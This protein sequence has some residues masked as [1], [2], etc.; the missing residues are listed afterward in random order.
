MLQYRR[1]QSV[2][3]LTFL[4]QVIA[5]A[6][7]KVMAKWSLFVIMVVL[8]PATIAEKSLRSNKDCEGEDTTI[9]MDDLNIHVSDSDQD[10][11]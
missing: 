11:M 10:L 9:D 5:M 8:C 4:E 3:I 2:E 1:V 6:G 7:L